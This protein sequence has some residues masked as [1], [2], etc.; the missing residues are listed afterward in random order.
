MSKGFSLIELLVVVSVLGILAAVAVPAYTQ[1]RD[2]VIVGGTLHILESWAKDAAQYYAKRGTWPDSIN[3]GSVSLSNWQV[4]SIG[5]IASGLYVKGSDGKGITV[6]AAVSNLKGVPGYVSPTPG[7]PGANG[8]ANSGANTMYLSIRDV[9]GTFVTKCG[10]WSN[11]SG[12]QAV[13]FDY[14]PSCQCTNI[15]AFSYFGNT[16]FSGCS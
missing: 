11:T 4:V 15:S 3:Y 16:S 6:G 1:Y 2:K 13:P 8:S 10:A 7:L 14:W 5:N 12:N 9:N